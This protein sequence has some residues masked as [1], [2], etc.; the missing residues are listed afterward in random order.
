MLETLALDA[1]LILILLMLIPI[2]MYRGGLREICSAAGFLLGFVVAQQWSSRWGEWVGDITSIDVGIAR[3]VVAVGTMVLLTGLIGYGAAAAFAYAPGPGGR[4]Y[5]GLISLATGI[6]FLGAVIQFVTQYLYDGVYPDIIREGYASRALSVGFDWV[7]LA[8]SLAMLLATIFGMIVRERETDEMLVEVPREAGT[9]SRRA[10]PVPAMAPEPVN[11]EPIEA[12]R[13]QADPVAGTAAVKIRE[14]RHWEEQTPPTLH[15]LQS[16]WTRTWPGAVTT[17][18]KP[19]HDRGLPSQQS[20]PA[21]SS[22]RPR[23]SPDEAVIR[24]WLETDQKTDRR[25]LP[26]DRPVEDE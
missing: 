12:S 25:N 10:A 14:V 21:A 19:F 24:D 9:F 1:M 16:G 2:G 20:R 3:F 6:V 22:R 15:D 11:L 13:P 4:L 5:G 7:L 8:V 26:A 17:D 23:E 18:A